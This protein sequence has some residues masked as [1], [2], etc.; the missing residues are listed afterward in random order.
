MK[1]GDFFE[2]YRECLRNQVWRCRSARAAARHSRHH[3]LRRRVWHRFGSQ[4]RKAAARHF[5][6]VDADA[7][8]G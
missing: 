7:K 1:C 6:K 5:A 8:R 3:A 4:K 2:A